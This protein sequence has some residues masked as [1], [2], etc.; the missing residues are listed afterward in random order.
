MCACV[1]SSASGKVIVGLEEAGQV[2]GLLEWTPSTAAI[3]LALNTFFE[4][5]PGG[6]FYFKVNH[7]CYW[8]SVNLWTLK[9]SLKLDD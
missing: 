8:L 4:K 5:F 2:R 6:N 3:S 7:Y 1:Q 9:A